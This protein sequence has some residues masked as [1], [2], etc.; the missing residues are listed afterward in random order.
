VKLAKRGPAA[1]R[2]LRIGMLAP[3]F[4]PVPP[5][6]YGGTERVIHALAEGLHERG[7]AVTL[8]ASGDSD[9]SCALVPTVPRA[10]WVGGP[11]DVGECFERVIDTAWHRAGEFDLIHS[12][13]DTRGFALARSSPTPVITT[14]HGRLDE[15]ATH[16]ALRTF[17]D[18]PLV[19]ISECQIESAPWANWQ[20][21]IGHGLRLDRMPFSRR[22]GDYLL[23]VG[24]IT[25]EKGV[26]EA[27]KVARRARCR[28][29][30]VAKIH[31]PAESVL[32]EAEVRPVL[33]AGRVEYAGELE[34]ALRDPLFA[35][36]L[37]T[38]M[39]GNW[40]EP[41]GLV[42][43][44]SLAT[45]TPVIALRRGAL[46]HI[47]R[48]GLD[49]FVV[50]DLAGAEQAIAA[51]H[52]LD[53][54]QIRSCAIRR[55]SADRMVDRYLSLYSHLLGTNGTRTERRLPSFAKV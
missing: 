6:R 28:L 9:V 1:T 3:P 44:E 25:P 5:P 46:P 38:L 8:F 7:H 52:S 34:P 2:S 11:A 55:F 35:G 14:M 17:P 27:I 21:V 12:H 48:D 51:V 41:F 24:R 39:L 10:C 37:A 49:G 20:A 26:L 31:D 43:I 36:A 54:T 23:F 33:S 19:A 30:I 50:D 32:F 18:V 45:G 15:P 22:S 47:V 42:A 4:L 29:I 16:D 53:R 40:P 13:L